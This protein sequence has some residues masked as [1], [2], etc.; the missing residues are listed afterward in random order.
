MAARS[1]FHKMWPS[2]TALVDNNCRSA[3]VVT[4]CCVRSPVFWQLRRKEGCHLRTNIK[5]EKGEM[6]FAIARAGILDITGIVIAD[7]CT[8]TMW[9]LISY[10]VALLLLEKKPV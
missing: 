5:T 4:A 10:S 6:I 3:K 7:H 1:G 8:K 2:E 9:Y